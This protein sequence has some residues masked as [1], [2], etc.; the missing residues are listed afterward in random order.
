M[1][2]TTRG[3]AV[4]DTNVL[5]SGLLSSTGAPGRILD[6]VLA[7]A[8]EPVLTQEILEEYKEVL[9]REALALPAGRVDAVLEFLQQFVLPLPVAAK[10]VCHDPDDDK[11][12]AA[13]LEGGAQWLITGN[14]RHY[15][16]SPFQGVLI[17][18]PAEA[19]RRIP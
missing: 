17:L 14:A 10:R 6:F 2:P 13:A 1:K 3:R 18:T 5:V 15:P 7:G 16:R 12:V 9:S 4:L 19:T 8:V 11:F